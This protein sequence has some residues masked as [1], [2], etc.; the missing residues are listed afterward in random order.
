MLRRWCSTLQHQSH[1]ISSVLTITGYP[2]KGAVSWEWPTPLGAP[3]TRPTQEC[4]LVPTRLGSRNH[5]N[6]GTLGV[7]T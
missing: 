5:Q 6:G 3:L 2:T 4:G 7:D 1:G